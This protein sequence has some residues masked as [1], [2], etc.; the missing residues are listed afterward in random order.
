[1]GAKFKFYEIVRVRSTSYSI[2]E[3]ISGSLGAILGIGEDELGSVSYSVHIYDKGEVW[4]LD[5][6][7]LE[8]TGEMDKEDNFYDGS[9]IKVE[10]DKSGKGNIK[11]E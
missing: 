5:E 6:K 9:S 3:E 4:D 11:N 7:L 10:I 2:E 1:M 8:S